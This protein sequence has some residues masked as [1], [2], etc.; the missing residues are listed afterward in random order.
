MLRPPEG[1]E[2]VYTLEHELEK[3]HWWFAARR[4]RVGQLL[5][6]ALQERSGLLLLDVGCGSGLNARNFERHGRVLGLDLSVAPLRQ[7]AREGRWRLGGDATRIPFRDGT[8]DAITALDILE[9]LDS[10]FSAVDEMFRVLRPGG[11]LIVSVPAC[12]VLFGPHD[13]ILGH[14]RRYSRAAVEHLL[15]RTER[16][17]YMTSI[18]FP[19][20][21]SWRILA[22]LLG[23]P[24][25]RSDGGIRLP[26]WANRTLE[27][28]M[29]FEAAI[30]RRIPFGFGGSLLCC[31]RKR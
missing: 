3:S 30:S 8:F 29:E 1:I 7:D 24:P 13:Q 21:L 31:S 23:G 28:V 15:R 18:M 22:K 6:M 27:L 20:L 25:K 9:H 19:L 4:G 14:Q 12:P 2:D 5:A 11:V 17:E 26:G 10:D 16:V